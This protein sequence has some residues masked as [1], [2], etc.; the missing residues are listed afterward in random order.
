MLPFR[1]KNADNLYIFVGQI[2]EG[3]REIGFLGFIGFL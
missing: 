1:A 3:I 2:K